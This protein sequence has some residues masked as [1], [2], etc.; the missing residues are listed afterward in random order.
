[1]KIL[2]LLIAIAPLAA[3]ADS[4]SGK[5]KA[6]HMTGG[7]AIGA[8]VLAATK[9]EGYA[10]AAGCGAGIAKEVWDSKRQNHTAS[11]KDA[12]V[13]C[14]GTYIGIKASGIVLTA[15]GINYSKAF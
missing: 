12:A 2:A 13:T 4:W 9:S 3:S 15:R 5:D 6:L 7:A 14:A 10:L 11:V 1:M 8:A